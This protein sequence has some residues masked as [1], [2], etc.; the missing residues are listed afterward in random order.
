MAVLNLTEYLNGVIRWRVT[1]EVERALFTKVTAL[2]GLRSFEDPAFHGQLRLAEQ[3]AARE[4]I[5]GKNAIW[6]LTMSEVIALD[7]GKP[8]GA[9]GKS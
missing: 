7:M 9:E 1:L 2:D 3:A 5:E 8:E 6:S 4:Q